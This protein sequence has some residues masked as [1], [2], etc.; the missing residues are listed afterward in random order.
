M[1]KFAGI[2]AVLVVLGMMGVF[3]P[4]SSADHDCVYICPTFW[5]VSDALWG[6][7][8]TCEAAYAS[9]VQAVEAQ[10][11]QRCGGDVCEFGT[12]TEVTPC[13]DKDGMKRVDVTTQYKCGRY[14]CTFHP[15]PI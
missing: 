1:R 13:M 4:E 8:A 12:I 7:E 10:A 9:A 5:S 2:A 15:E 11:Y 14:R 3:V 6:V